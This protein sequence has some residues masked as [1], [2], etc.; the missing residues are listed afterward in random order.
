MKIKDL[1]TI[2]QHGEFISAVQLSD[3][4]NP[5]KNAQLVSQYIFS[6]ST[7]HTYG[8]EKR[9]FGSI[10]LLDKFRKAFI[11]NANNA[12]MIFADFG[13]GKSHFAL[14]AMNYFDKPYNSPEIRM[15]L[16]R[17]QSAIPNNQPRSENFVTFKKS[18][19]RFL[20]LSLTGDLG[21][22]IEEMLFASLKKGLSR[23][24]ETQNASLPFWNE[25]AVD[26][27]NERRD[28]KK[29]KEF[30]ADEL[31]TDF[32]NLVADV[33]TNKDGAWDQYTKLFQHLNSGASP[34]PKGKKN[35]KEVL[36]W[37]IKQFVGDGKPFSGVVIFFDE[38]SQFIRVYI[39]GKMDASLQNLLSGVTEN[40]QKVLFIG[41]GHHDPIETAKS[42]ARNNSTID[43]ISKEL[44]RLEEKVNLYSLVESILDASLSHSQENWETLINENPI[45]K[46]GFLGTTAEYSWDLYL[47]RYEK[48][49][50]WD[51]A[52]FREVVVKGCY[53]LHP[54]TTGLLAHLKMVSDLSDDARTMLRFVREV[55]DI[56]KDEDVM[57]GNKVNWVYPIELVDFFKEKIANSTLYNEYS[58]AMNN[59]NTILAENVTENQVKMLKAILVQRA[60]QK[61]KFNKFK[62]I[63]LLSHYCGLTTGDGHST[64]K[65]LK[66][67]NILRY[68]EYPG[69]FTFYQTGVDIQALEIEVKKQLSTQKFDL[70]SSG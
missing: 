66:E 26:W 12:L 1:V 48:E 35:P 53:P 33:Q 60:D 58:S 50:R 44:T 3:F 8:L 28:N 56:K 40:K 20:V 52:K 55:Y 61:L 16:E 57:I 11:S 63:E 15:I 43:D 32:V 41:L 37:V 30:L 22:S 14:E 47:E 25:K 24:P 2:D 21:K 65:S 68:E 39:N 17:I 64:L 70:N 67:H 69:V 29:G 62:Q 18:R 19:D 9:Y 27:L 23:H 10:D 31:K 42:Y 46:G 36:D 59:L 49:L 6:E 4:E 54:T 45:A 7:P 5:V 38:F 51:N 13:H 34:D